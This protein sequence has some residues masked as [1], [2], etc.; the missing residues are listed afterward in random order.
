[1]IPEQP[2][3][4]P[5]GLNI[6]TYGHGSGI[7]AGSGGPST[8]YSKPAWQSGIG[9]PNNGVRDLP[10]VSLFASS[11]A[12]YSFWPICAMSS[13]CTTNNST[14]GAVN[15]FGVGG[16][17]ASSPA[18]AGVMALVD[19]AT[20]SRQG[21][22]D[23][24]LYPLAAQFPSVFHDV[25]AGSNMVPCQ[26]GYPNCSTFDTNLGYYDLG[27]Y[28][29]TGYDMATGLGTVDISALIANWNAV[30]F[31]TTS[32]TLSLSPSSITH[33]QSVT[34]NASVTP[35]SGSGTPTGTL[36][37]TGKATGATKQTG[38]GTVSLTSGSANTTLP[39]LPGGSYTVS[40]NYSGDGIYSS[41]H[42]TGSTITVLPEASVIQFPA[43]EL[44]AYSNQTL[45]FGS[46]LAILAQVSGSS[47]MGT[48]T[49]TV[50][51]KD[52]VGGQATFPLNSAG[53]AEWDVYNLAMGIHTI[54]INYSGD[55]SFNATTTPAT[56]SFTIGK[57]NLYFAAV[58]SATRVLAGG[59]LSA[60]ITVFGLAGTAPTGTIT[61]QFGG[62]S[63]TA[64]LVP[65]TASN[66]AASS[67][68]V[69][70]SNLASWSSGYIYLA[71]S[72]DANWSSF[73][74]R[75]T[76]TY[77]N[78]IWAGPY[79]PTTTTLTLS[80]ISN[81]YNGDVTVTGKVSGNG[82]IAPTGSVGVYTNVDGLLGNISLSA[83]GTSASYTGSIP[84]GYLING[85]N[86]LTAVYS[87]DSNYL[88]SAS[89]PLT[90]TANI[91]D[92]ALNALTPV[93]S[94][95]PGSSVTE[96]LI[97]TST[98]TAFGTTGSVTIQCTTSSPAITCTPA[99][100]SSTLTASGQTATSVTIKAY[101]TTTSNLIPERGFSRW[102]PG[103]VVLSCLVLLWVPGKRR[104][105]GIL[106]CLI[107][108]IGAGFVT[109]CGGGGST[110]TPSGPGSPPPTTTTTNAGPGTYSVVVTA[111][112][113]NVTHSVR[114]TVNVQ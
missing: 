89:L 82:V 44:T 99:S 102:L 54:S 106:L 85:N 27:Y 24:V 63:Q 98:G 75:P 69:A 107:L 38:L 10:D 50:T 1:M 87:G 58:P 88:S 6:N 67:A 39:S 12:N 47:G 73:L 18:F 59:S 66:L 92:F 7:V 8:V 5:L 37:L 4:D 20:G 84:G 105:R 51:F 65:S 17:S 100:T 91:G 36:A 16:T 70:F 110:T 72:G 97:L 95:A 45:P 22:A 42:S 19:Q 93:L 48:P 11:G 112:A 68:T 43:A 49:G 71:Y 57:G 9:V 40:A 108:F 77:V 53:M 90:V 13:D 28:S 21:Q 114:F 86:Q 33:G 30:S 55:A 74:S 46:T 34:V 35:A 101:T 3:N 14:T 94:V 60:Q 25:T 26:L 23:Y 52:S 29:T 2:W 15:I 83:S 62:Q 103:G 80:S 109:S 113:S 96:N 56:M 79:L 111:I 61:A 64:T 32:T 104:G 31:K 41:S 76:R 81:G 78:M